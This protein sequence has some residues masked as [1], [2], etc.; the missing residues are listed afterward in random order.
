MHNYNPE[1]NYYQLDDVI[2]SI[3]GLTDS[4]KWTRNAI[5]GGLFPKDVEGFSVVKLGNNI[6][7]RNRSGSS[8]YFYSIY[9]TESWERAEN[10]RSGV[11]NRDRHKVIDLDPNNN[12]H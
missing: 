3:K 6:I 5:L 11:E 2:A 8:S 10:Y 7:T 9:T 4:M 1:L 12:A